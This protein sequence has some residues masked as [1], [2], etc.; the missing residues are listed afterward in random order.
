MYNRNIYNI[1]THKKKR[2]TRQK[3]NKVTSRSI[4]RVLSCATIYL[5]PP[6]PTDSSDVKRQYHGEQPYPILPYLASGGVYIC[7]RSYLLSG[8]L[9]P[10]LFILTY[11]G[12]CFLLHF[13]GSHLRRTLSVTLLCEARTFLIRFLFRSRTVDSL[14]AYFNTK[15]FDCKHF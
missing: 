5:L 2:I 8:E 12:G 9:L 6:L 3:T 10:R 7:E 1:K 15:P 11:K 13:P 4:S 14:Q